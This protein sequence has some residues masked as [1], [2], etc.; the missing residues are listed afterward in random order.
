MN[1]LVFR[2]LSCVVSIDFFSE[3]G[4]FTVRLRTFLS[5]S[6]LPHNFSYSV[7]KPIANSNGS[8]TNSK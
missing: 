8:A 5:H 1:I 7:N 6:D 3:V 2:N 4:Y